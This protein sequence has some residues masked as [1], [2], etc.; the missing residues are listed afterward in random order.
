[1]VTKTPGL[2]RTAA[3]PWQ[4]V[5]ARR[6]RAFEARREC[7][8]GWS[9]G[10]FSTREAAERHL[11]RLAG[12]PCHGDELPQ[13]PRDVVEEHLNPEY[14][15]ACR[16]DIAIGERYFEYLGEASAYQSGIRYCAACAER[17]WSVTV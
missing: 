12:S 2:V 1:M 3:K 10:S 5:G 7:E 15:P 14:S 17:V 9:S 16:G 4:C 11:A 6:V 13:R 8:H